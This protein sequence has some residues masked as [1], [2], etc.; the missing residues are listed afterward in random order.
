MELVIRINI[1]WLESALGK[2]KLEQLL[3]RLTS[4]NDFPKTMIC[5]CIDSGEESCRPGADS[6]ILDMLKSIVD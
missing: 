1:D 4:A 5:I 2:E 6:V 3:D